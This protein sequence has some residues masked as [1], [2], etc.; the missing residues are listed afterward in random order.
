[1]DH[2]TAPADT[3]A[4]IDQVRELL[5]GDHR[6]ATEGSLKSFDDKLAAFQATLEARFADLE[7]R[8]TD[9]QTHETQTHTQ[10]VAAVGAALAELG[11]RIKG[12]V[13]TPQS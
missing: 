2:E 12:L 7:R 13:H 9:A 10:N 4:V 3:N 5:F 1:M 11:D 6:R 8:L